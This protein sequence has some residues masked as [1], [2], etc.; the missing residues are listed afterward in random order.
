[1][2]ITGAIALVT[3]ANRGIGKEF[4]KVLQNGGAAKIYACTR[5]KD[6]LSQIVAADPERIIPVELDITDEQQVSEVASQ[7]SDV[8]LLINNAGVGYDAGLISA[9][10]LSEAQKEM[11]VNYFGTLKMCRAF[12]PV[13]RN[14]G[15]GAIANVVSSLALVNLPARGG[16]SASKA[17]VHSMTQGVRAELASQG[18]LV[19]AVFPGAVDTDFS[20]DYDMQKISPTEVAEAGIQA[21][22]DDVEDVYPG[23]EAQN[24]QT[25]LR[26]D[27]KA[28]EKQLAQRLPD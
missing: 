24:A 18:T 23:E 9:P 11:E 3:G 6:K 4:V 1:M 27:P 17:A 13:L 7:C 19:V 14:N 26:E 21:V 20:K 28:L 8:T 12:A 22:I 25:Q 5:H 2:K 15:G 10:D 16:Y